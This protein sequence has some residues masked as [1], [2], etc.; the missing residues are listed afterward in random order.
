MIKRK[1]T[2]VELTL[3]VFDWLRGLPERD[4]TDVE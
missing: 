3:H 4:E 2:K 1:E